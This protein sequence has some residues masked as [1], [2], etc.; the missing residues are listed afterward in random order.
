MAAV[1]L[2]RV[3]AAGL[4]R[5]ACCEDGRV[6]LLREVSMVLGRPSRRR[7][8]RLCQ[9]AI[10]AIP[11]SQTLVEPRRERV[12]ALP[13]VAIHASDPRGV[14]AKREQRARTMSA[15]P[16]RR[17]Q[18]SAVSRTGMQVTEGRKPSSRGSSVVP[19]SSEST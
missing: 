1:G 6:Y 4:A 18:W 7:L 17:A 10:T 2:A 13:I 15:W 8:Q 12:G 14:G 3:A 11:E 9:I 5:S 19:T 16:A